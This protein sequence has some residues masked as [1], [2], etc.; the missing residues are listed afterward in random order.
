MLKYIFTAEFKDGTILGQTPEDLSLLEPEK[1]S[2]FYDVCQKEMESPLIR[3]SLIGDGH[4]YA[5]DL[6]DGHF[7]I[8]GLPVRMHEEK[9][10]GFK[11]IYFRQHTHSFNVGETSAKEMSHD[12]VFRM[13]WQCTVDGRNYQR[14]MQID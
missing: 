5:V 6:T 2:R 9:L 4:T 13:G 7:E 1:R 8:D 3:F 14:V 12:I 10:S 11:L